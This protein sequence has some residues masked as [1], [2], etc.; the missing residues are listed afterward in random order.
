MNICLEIPYSV[1]IGQAHRSFTRK[2]SV[3]FIAP[4]KEKL[5][6]KRCLRAK[7]YQA[8][9]VAVEVNASYEL[10]TILRYNTYIGHLRPGNPKLCSTF[11]NM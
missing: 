5:P 8:V 2:P 1:T 3:R 9:T 10:A 4:D 11:H 7:W 6:Q